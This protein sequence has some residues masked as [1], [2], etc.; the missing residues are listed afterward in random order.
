MARR[1]GAVQA[2]DADRLERFIDESS[3]RE[4]VDT[5]VTICYEKAEHI[6]SDWQDDSLAREW[7]KVG[8]LLD[9]V[10]TKLRSRGV[11]GIT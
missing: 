5:L 8:K 4:V 11:P 3:L 10:A 7:T 6:S 2:L 1:L 9:G